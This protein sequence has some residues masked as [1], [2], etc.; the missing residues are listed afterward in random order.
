MLKALLAIGAAL[1]VPLAP[2]LVLA[3]ALTGPQVQTQT[4]NASCAGW[5]GDT[6][7]SIEVDALQMNR[8][9]LIYAA[10]LETGVGAAGVT[11][12]R[13]SNVNTH[14]AVPVICHWSPAATAVTVTVPD[15]G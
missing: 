13:G 6:P 15:P 3:G 12:A 2:I 10:A 8:A 5:A 1:T 11:Y 9:A 7:A 14:D 4:I